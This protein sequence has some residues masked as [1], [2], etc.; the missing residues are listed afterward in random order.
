MLNAAERQQA[1][2]SGATGFGT[3]SPAGAEEIVREIDENAF[4]SAGS[5]PASVSR[6]VEENN[7]MFFLV[8]TI[9]SKVA[10]KLVLT[11]S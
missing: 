8:V 2:V 1:A 11:R 7:L 5:F 6:D 9:L 4:W 3:S 10:C